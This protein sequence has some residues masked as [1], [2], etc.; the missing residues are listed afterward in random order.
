M[1]DNPCDFVEPDERIDEAVQ[2][3]EYGAFGRYCIEQLGYKRR[4]ILNLT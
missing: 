2:G 3:I 4:R 1:I